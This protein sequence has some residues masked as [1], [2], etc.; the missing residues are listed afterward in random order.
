ME[1]AG[2]FLIIIIASFFLG[3]FGLGMKYNR[4]LAWEA[5]WSIHS[6][7]GMLVVPLLYALLVVP[8]LFEAILT[9]DKTAITRGCFFGFIWGIGGV[10]FGISIKYVGVSLTYGV[11]MGTTG[12]IGG[13]VPF[14]QMKDYA[15]NPGFNYII[16]GIIVILTGVAIIA[17]AGI[18]REKILS[19]QG[20]EIEGIKRGKEFW[21]GIFIV[22]VSGIFSSFLNIGYANAMPVAE[23]ALTFGASRINA[24]MAAW[25]VVLTGAVTFNL[26]YAIIL[27]AKNNTWKTFVNQS[28]GKA[29]FWA[30]LSA[31]LWFGSMAIYGIGAAMMGKL[32]PVIGWPVFVGL[33]LIF[34]NFWAFKAG[35]WSNTDKIKKILYLG[36]GILIIATAILAYSNF[37]QIEK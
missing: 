2:S 21:K 15:S 4:P 34:S 35:E 16:L 26:L 28:S 17:Y 30:V 5:F 27:L 11:V 14:F 33:S 19:K 36:V 29:Y 3:T 37:I 13:L 23:N 20:L 22:S 32:G 8:D 18:R 25:V 24:S 12:A 10:L 7:T 9:A 31:L 6:L 1:I